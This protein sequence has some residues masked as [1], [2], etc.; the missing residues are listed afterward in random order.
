MCVC[1]VCVFYL[2]IELIL[3]CT[4]MQYYSYD[5]HTYTTTILN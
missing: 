3:F 1:G 5:T 2:K 4:V